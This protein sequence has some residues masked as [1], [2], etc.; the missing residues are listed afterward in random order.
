M[1]Y[2]KCRE[3]LASKVVGRAAVCTPAGPRIMP[4]NFSVVD[5]A[6]VFRTTP[7]SVLGTYGWNTQLAFEVDD[8]DETGHTGWSVMALGRGTMVED[9]HELEEIRASD[10]P[11]P[12]AGGLRQLYVRLRWTEL[13]GRRIGG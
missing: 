11:T 1:T 9:P 12:W 10:D 7:Y 8:V 2:E 4:V 13:T 5:D 6:I 3:L